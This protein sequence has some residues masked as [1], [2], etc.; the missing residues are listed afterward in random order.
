MRENGLRGI[1][2]RI[3]PRAE[4]H[5]VKP[6]GIRDEYQQLDELLRAKYNDRRR[7]EAAEVARKAAL[8]RA[9][10]MRRMDEERRAEQLRSRQ[11]RARRDILSQATKSGFIDMVEHAA[12]IVATEERVGSFYMRNYMTTDEQEQDTLHIICNFPGTYDLEASVVWDATIN[13]VNGCLW[14]END[15]TKLQQIVADQ[16]KGFSWHTVART[17]TPPMNQHSYQNR[18]T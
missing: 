13:G 3:N 4:A 18:S 17:Y 14:E 8:K 7:Q 2:R 9:E 6:K 1:F 15:K 12:Q 5:I 16:F 11:E 10:E